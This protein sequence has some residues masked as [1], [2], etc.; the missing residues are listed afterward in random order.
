MKI[1]L[2]ERVY[3]YLK[4]S[5]IF[6]ACSMPDRK[7]PWAVEKYFS[8]QASPANKITGGFFMNFAFMFEGISMCCAPISE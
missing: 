2:I 4:K 6:C 5:T 7:A 1:S 8:W 3:I